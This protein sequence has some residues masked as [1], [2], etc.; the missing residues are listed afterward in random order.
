MKEV[1]RDLR[2]AR[3]QLGRIGL[4]AFDPGLRL[5][6]C[7]VVEVANPSRSEGPAKHAHPFLPFPIAYHRQTI[8]IR[9]MLGVELDVVP[10]RGAKPA[11]KANHLEQHADFPVLFDEPLE[12]RYKV[13]V[14]LVRQLAAH[15]H[16]EHLAA[17][18]FIQPYCHSYFPFREVSARDLRLHPY[19]LFLT[20]RN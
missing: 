5:A 3:R 19:T 12:R 14:V 8:D 4:L 13:L 17:I 6:N 15:L 18:R 1:G 10:Q 16:F 11:V 2:V 7:P 20:L 9:E